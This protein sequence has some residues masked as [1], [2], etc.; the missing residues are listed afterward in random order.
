MYNDPA[1]PPLLKEIQDWFGSIIRQKFEE[2][3]RLSSKEEE[4]SRYILPSKTLRSKERMEIYHQQYWWRLL[5]VLQENFPGLTR[6]LGSLPFKKTVAIPYLIAQAPTDFA[7][8]KLGKTLSDWLKSNYFE[9]NRESVIHVALIDWAMQKAFWGEQHLPLDTTDNILNRAL[10][11]Q[12]YLSLFSFSSDFFQF[13]EK[14][15]QK[16]IDSSQPLPKLTVKIGFFAVFRTPQN[17]IIW[18]EITETEYIILSSIDEGKTLGE[19]LAKI[20]ES[21]GAILEEA[22]NLL[23]LFFQH[24]T[25]L[26]WFTLQKWEKDA[27]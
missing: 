24:W 15:M 5:N 21:G 14:L 1:S 10:Y 26:G 19:A 13:R 23:P 18:K 20:E 25:L 17:P 7:L 22:L 12:P 11:L 27:F 9:E 4:T 3:E 6:L 2:N 16:E 8:C